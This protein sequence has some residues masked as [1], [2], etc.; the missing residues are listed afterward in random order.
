MGFDTSQAAAQAAK[1]ST[2]YNITT[3]VVALMLVPLTLRF[4]GR[5]VYAL[6]LFGTAAA[7]F[8][9]SNITDPQLVLIPMILFGVG[10]AAMMGIPYTMVSKIVPQSRRGIYMGILNMMIV[11]PMGIETL[12]FGPIYKYVLG[13]SP[14][15]AMLFGGV[16]FVIAGV[17]AFRLKAKDAQKVYDGN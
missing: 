6:S 5:K 11:I 17:L 8:M 13:S 7:L 2:T 16:F 14:V 15:N 12:T 4:G 9:I 10:W 3:V 1:M